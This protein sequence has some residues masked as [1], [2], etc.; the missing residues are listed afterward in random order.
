MKTEDEIRD[1]IV[2]L[3][4]GRVVAS[5]KRRLLFQIDLLS[6]EGYELHAWEMYLLGQIAALTWILNK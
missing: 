1:E 4:E 2:R 6:I 3:N 5:N